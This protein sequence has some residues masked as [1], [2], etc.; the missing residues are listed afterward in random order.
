MCK[1]VEHTTII[2][3]KRLMICVI[4][5]VLAILLSET[6]YAV[7][8][9][10]TSTFL[11]LTIG[12]TQMVLDGT[13]SK[14]LT[15]KPLI[16]DKPDGTQIPM[17]P[18]RSV[19]EVLGY[20]VEWQHESK[21]TVI[22]GYQHTI[23]LDAVGQVILDRGSVSNSEVLCQILEGNL[24]VEAYFFQKYCACDVIWDIIQQKVTI[25]GFSPAARAVGLDQMNDYLAQTGRAENGMIVAIIDTG[26]DCTHPYLR[27]RIVLP[28][29]FTT[30]QTL[31]T[32]EAGHG[33]H[34]AGI[35]ANCT[36][37][38]VKIM[39]LKVSTNSSDSVG[40]I[41]AAIQYAVQNNAKVVNI[42]LVA[43]AEGSQ[44]LTNAVDAAFDAGCVVVAAAG[45]EHDDTQYYS[46]AGT[47]NAIVVT[48]VDNQ[49]Q[50]LS[51]SNYGDTV[52]V[53]AP[54]LNIVS[55]L[56]G[57]GYDQK[58][59][60]SVATPFVSSAVAM[61]R[62]DIPDIRPSEIKNLLEEYSFGRKTKEKD[63]R[64]GYGVLSLSQYV[65]DSQTGR[66]KIFTETQQER[67]DSLAQEVAEIQR[68][69]K[70]E[71]PGDDM[72][73]RTFY[74]AE[75]INSALSCYQRHEYFRAGYYLEKAVAA[76]DAAR[77]V[78]KNNLAFML[79]RGEY[80]SYDYSTRGLLSASIA[81]GQPLAYVNMALL[82]ASNHNWERA[83]ELMQECCSTCSEMDRN[84]ILKTWI[85]LAN[86]GDAEGHLVVAW[87]MRFQ[88][89]SDTVVSQQIHLN[90]AQKQYP[91]IPD[92]LYTIY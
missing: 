51:D 43:P 11:E 1:N 15:A 92:W 37:E 9:R 48:G 3:G 70:A 77:G 42:S 2:V 71:R 63:P 27:N 16:V 83:D 68:K 80:V 65:T 74:A 18:I 39:P 35:I 87:L 60:S 73:I 20:T 64:Y 36:P 50:I 12:R 88:R 24:L 47:K 19:A 22:T 84:E 56:S 34:V 23:I 28:Y 54:G 30:Q 91:D 31:V 6:V 17:V 62:M 78:G 86:S 10:T 40:Q 33:T 75:L 66:A 7:D 90:L 46:P 85:G 49:N 8:I 69:V 67:F 89:Y 81:V 38:S 57:G 45:N 58:R 26:V 61:L 25:A 59:G 76:G 44:E 82:E 4:I 52:T 13:Q 21:A 41:T 29:D 55:T 32:D 5:I 53:S 79:R 14:E 72:L